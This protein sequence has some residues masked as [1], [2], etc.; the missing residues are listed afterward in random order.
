MIWGS[1]ICAQYN[2][3]WFISSR[4]L[5]P[6][7]GWL[8]WLEVAGI[9]QLEP[10]IWA[11][12]CCGLDDSVLLHVTSQGVNMSPKMALLLSDAQDRMTKIAGLPGHLSLFLLTT[13]P[14]G[15]HGPHHSMAMSCSQISYMAASFPRVSIL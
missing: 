11:S 3:R 8:D 10:Y 5:G 14:C 6:Y 9:T 1:G 7:L 12:F 4:C 2:R 15:Y 13:C